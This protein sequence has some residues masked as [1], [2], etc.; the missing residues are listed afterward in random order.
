MPDWPH[1]PH[2]PDCWPHFPKEPSNNPDMIVPVDP[3]KNVPIMNNLVVHDA[4]TQQL[5]V[6]HKTEQKSN[7]IEFNIGSGKASVGVGFENPHTN[8]HASVSGGASI[9]GRICF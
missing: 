8:V 9:G 4:P 6:E 2:A 5:P 7:C 3:L 1:F